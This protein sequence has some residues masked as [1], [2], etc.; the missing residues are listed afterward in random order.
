MGFH[1]T[2]Y[3]CNLTFLTIATANDQ[4]FIVLK[5]IAL[6][7]VIRVAIF[8]ILSLIILFI[9]EEYMVYDNSTS[10][11]LKVSHFIIEIFC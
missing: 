7:P 10:C 11:E 4:I 5:Q 6:L 2:S 8:R 1:S 9:E 3:V